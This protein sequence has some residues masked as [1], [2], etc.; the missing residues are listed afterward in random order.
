[1]RIR[2]SQ[3]ESVPWV[4]LDKEIQDNMILLSNEVI[5]SILIEEKVE[6][7]F[8]KRTYIREC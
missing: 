4:F 6:E 3:Y 5:T 7:I 2:Y 1:M 8:D